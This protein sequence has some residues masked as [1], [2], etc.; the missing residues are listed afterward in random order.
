MPSLMRSGLTA[1]NSIFSQKPSVSVP[2]SRFNLGRL[3]S[4]TSSLGMI[5]PVDV[6]PTLP[7]DEF[8]LS[9]QYQVDFR[10]V[11]APMFTAYKVK[12]HYYY[13]PNEYLW[14]GWESFIT[15]G[16]S[17]KLQ[18]Q[19]PTI[20]LKS[21]STKSVAGKFPT[22]DDITD[23]FG[24]TGL[25]SYYPYSPMSLAS[26]MA[27]CI[28]YYT[29]LTAD[30]SS[31]IPDHYLPFADSRNVLRETGFVKPA[32]N[33]LPFLMYQKIF[34]SN[35]VDPNLMSNGTVESEA[36]FP[37]DIDSSHWRFDYAASNLFG[38]YRNYFVP[39]GETVPSTYRANFVPVPHPSGDDSTGDNC[40]NLL[41]L[42]YAMWTDDMFT[43][44]LPF[45]QRGS[46]ASL[47]FDI[48]PTI[49]DLLSRYG[50]S[51]D[52]DV[53]NGNLG[54]YLGS[55]SSSGSA[56]TY[57]A[58]VAGGSTTKQVF[59]SDDPSNN[60]LNKL[61][62]IDPN[63]V[64]S[65][66]FTA[67]NLRELIALSVWQERNALTNG[68]YGQFI[69]VHYDRYPDNEFCEPIYIGGT[70][71]VFNTSQVLQTSASVMDASG[72]LSG[73]PQGN[74]V[75]VSGSSQNNSIGRFVAKDYGFIMAL[76][77]I[78][79]DT[80][81]VQNTERYETDVN[82]DDYYMPEYERLSYQPI[83]NRQLYYDGN[84]DDTHALGLF[85]Y[86]NRY[87]YLKQRDS[88]ANGIFGLPAGADAQLNAY[89][90]KRV[91]ASQPVL[92]QNFV[93]VY[94]PNIDRS[95]LA[96]PGEPEF[97]VQF[98]SSVM[99]TRALSYASQPNTFGF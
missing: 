79:P 4:F 82:P 50:Y 24:F 7:G 22:F 9:A 44:A 17:G 51:S 38:T 92:S 2:R 85:G 57:Y 36:W 65:I 93:T 80:T 52:D 74:P 64:N 31:G 35:Y 28:P 54:F 29:D 39:Q 45:L 33:A 30:G 55:A 58:N 62:A 3:N 40:V 1:E 47:S 19:V 83:L 20:D 46:Q 73:T 59:V 68:S 71:S 98:Y 77:M 67:Q 42:R 95:F 15:K 72:N 61:M 89:V 56:N 96:S 37:D 43:T 27:R 97:I 63:S 11:L 18:L 5:V 16:R 70:T 6:F 99:A 69:K 10:P 88:V 87:V 23:D 41:Q 49:S 21:L 75:G 66:V 13:C 48:F 81:Y 94:P 86:S 8:D 84:D 60:G 12:V 34:R 76:M 25:T 91:F 26:Y 14:S 32:V 53:L 78:I 90:Q